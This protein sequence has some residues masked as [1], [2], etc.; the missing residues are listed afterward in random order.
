MLRMYVND[1]TFDMLDNRYGTFKM[2]MYTNM[3][4][5]NDT[6][7]TG[8]GQDGFKDIEVPIIPCEGQKVAW[9]K[10]RLKHYCTNFG[11]DHWLYGGFSAEKFSWMR[12]ILHECDTNER[13][14]CASDSESQ[15]YF[16]KTIIGIQSISKELSINETFS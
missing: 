16:E 7:G 3:D 12:L 10:N 11:E 15:E 14:D 4:S 6:I 1:P 13:D 2:H 5:I 8:K 9:K